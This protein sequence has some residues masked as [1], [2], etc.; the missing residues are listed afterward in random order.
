MPTESGFQLLTNRS[1]M[2]WV[3]GLEL[4][5]LHVM[6]SLLQGKV[7]M[8]VVVGLMDSEMSPKEIW[9]HVQSHMSSR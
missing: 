7:N 5:V 6:S 8:I 2:F 4:H 3:L 1:P 9:E